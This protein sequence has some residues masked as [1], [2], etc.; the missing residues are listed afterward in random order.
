MCISRLILFQSGLT[1]LAIEFGHFLSVNLSQLQSPSVFT[2]IFRQQLVTL[3][4]IEEEDALDDN[5]H[6]QVI[7]RFLPEMAKI[8]IPF[9]FFFWVLQ[10]ACSMVDIKRAVGF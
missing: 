7:F 3:Q 4:R 1:Q 6:A 5:V 2:E 10:I 9:F 8:D